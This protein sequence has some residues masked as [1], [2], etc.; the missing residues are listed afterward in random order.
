M[1]AGLA[2]IP[3][4]NIALLGG[5]TYSVRPGGAS[6]I[7]K[8]T[9][10]IHNAFEVWKEQGLSLGPM[11]QTDEQTAKH[12]VGKGYVAENKKRE[13][14]GTFSL[15]EG[16]VRRAGKAN[17]LFGEDEDTIKYGA[18]GNIKRLPSGRLLVF[19]KAAVKR[20]TA[21]SGLGSRLYA[22]AEESGRANGYSGMALETVKEAAWLYDWYKRLGFEPVGAYRFPGRQVDTVLMIKPFGRRK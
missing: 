10:L 14:V 8:V 6:D 12:L 15:D 2:R 22:L 19:K 4:T 9:A 18:I 7:S 16:R 3:N 1:T 20:D 17:L 11:Y 13:I 5:R 21:H